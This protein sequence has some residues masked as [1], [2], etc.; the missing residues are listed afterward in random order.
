MLSLLLDSALTRRSL[1]IAAVVVATAL[2]TLSLPVTL[3]L[4]WLLAFHPSLRGLARTLMFVVSYLWCEM[5]GIAVAAWLWVRF[6][7]PH[8]ASPVWSRYL[9]ANQ[10]LQFAWANALKRATEVIFALRFNV[11]GDEALRGSG[12]IVFARHASLGDTVIPIVF[13]AMPQGIRLR[14]VLK[15]E[16]L[17]D[18]CLDIVATACPT[19][20]STAM[21]MMRSPKS[22]RS[23]PWQH[24]WPMPKAC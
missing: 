7:A 13:Y 17:L 4:A 11:T 6:R 15:R 2:L 22:P 1:T 14:Y 8:P 20:S 16:L 3:P 24:T 18:P 19:T 21:Q 23:R 9:A 5:F 12:A 10:R